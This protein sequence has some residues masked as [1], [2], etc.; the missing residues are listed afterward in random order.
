LTIY[1]N[2]AYFGNDVV[3]V[4]NASLHYYGKHASEL[5]LPQAALIAGLIKA[6]AMCSP[7][8]HPD[9]AKMRRDA[10]IARCFRGAQSAPNKLEQRCK[11]LFADSLRKCNVA[12]FNYSQ[13]I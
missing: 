10:V 6:P 4:E 2:R 8:L 1:L 11:P 3:G 9:R 12:R 5:N 13:G 7:E